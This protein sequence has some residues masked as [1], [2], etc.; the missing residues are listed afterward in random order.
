[1]AKETFEYQGTKLKKWTDQGNH[2][3][4]YTYDGAGRKIREVIAGRESTFAYDS[5]GRLSTLQEE[6]GQATLITSYEYDNLD[7]LTSK[8]CKDSSGNIL[9]IGRYTYDAEG[10]LE[11]IKKNINDNE[12]IETFSYDSQNRIVSTQNALGYI[13][14]TEYDET[15]VNSLG[16]QVLQKRVTQPNKVIKIETFDPYEHVAKNEILNP[17]GATVSSEENF[18][19]P[20]GNLSLHMQHVYEGSQYINTKLTAYKND[21]LDRQI[22]FTRAFQTPHERTTRFTY[23]PGGNVKTK[24]KPDGTVLSYTYDPFG[25]IKQL[26]SSD[27]TIHHSFVYN[28][29]GHLRKATDEVQH[30]EI[31]RECDPFGNV[32]LETF[33][34]GLSITKTYDRL[35]RPLEVTLPDNSKIRYT[36][37]P[38]FC[39]GV[40]RLS[41]TGEVLYT[42]KYDVYDLNGNL[43]TETLIKDGGKRHHTTDL[44]N[45]IS[46]IDSPHFTQECHY[47]EVNNL[48]ELTTECEKT[49]YAY[50]HLNQLNSENYPDNFRSYVHDSAWNRVKEG[51]VDRKF[52]AL[53][54]LEETESGKYGYDLNGN[55]YCRIAPEVS[56]DYRYDALNRLTEVTSGNSK[57]TFL[58]DPLGRKLVKTKLQAVGDGEEFSKTFYLYD[59]NC[60]IGSLDASGKFRD[61][62]ITGISKNLI[63]TAVALELEEKLYTPIQDTQGNTRKLLDSIS[64]MILAKNDFSAFGELL[65]S[66]TGVLDPWRYHAKRFD[67]DINLIDYG[68]RFY[69]P[70]LGRWMTTDPAG[71]ID[72]MNLYAYLRNNP[73]KYCDP[74]GRFAFAIP[75]IIGTFCL[76]GEVAVGFV[77]T[78]IVVATLIAVVETFAV[79]EGINLVR[80][81]FNDC[82][83][84]S[85]EVQ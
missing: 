48:T 11:T 25:N 12:A 83:S 51:L 60:D 61:L 55:L 54:E 82:H 45:R 65:N 26:V 78:E 14:T 43:T 22:S 58:Y 39:K 1:M 37:N 32:T 62:R 2:I 69:C 24:T 5:L 21:C 85:A 34:T 40:E 80:K 3:T 30:V 42:H 46:N 76:G 56:V 44:K 4:E 20:C 84:E 16:Q 66:S 41:A 6:N 33:S 64:G 31:A 68:K 59:G 8:I 75:L 74:D 29:L 49:T 77:T 15:C 81:G 36:Y 79:Y 7:Q 23:Y 53:D 52:N 10:N 67:P 72:T 27:G 57:I 73:F 18:Y 50:D 28:T 19:D 35:N 63:P 71:F 13:T 70:S 17:A 47:D 9:K 38:L